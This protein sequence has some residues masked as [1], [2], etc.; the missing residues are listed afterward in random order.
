MLF[1]AEKPGFTRDVLVLGIGNILWSDEGFG[2]RAAEAFHQAFSDAPGLDV[3]DGG[4]LGYYLMNEIMESRALLVFDCCDFHEPPGSLHV[5]M[6][7]HVAAWQTTKISPHQTGFNDLLAT[8]ALL[9]R[10][11]GRLAVVGL[12]PELLE[13]YGGSLSETV[14][15]KIPEALEA[16]RKVLE[17]WGVRLE[18]RPGG[19]KVPSLLADSLS[20]EAYESGRPSEEAACRTGDERFMTMR[21]GT[22]VPDALEKE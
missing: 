3:M 1:S 16:A 21:A 22:A 14:R 19:A 6:D 20:I 17:G 12:Q 9:G 2:P 15:S 7:G 8:A 4:T 11:P 13:D 5:L 18:R 10:R